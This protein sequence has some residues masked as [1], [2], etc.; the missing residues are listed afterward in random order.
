[1]RGDG[2]D[3]QWVVFPGGD[4]FLSIFER[5]FIRGGIRGG[6]FEDRLAADGPQAC[7]RSRFSDIRLEIIH[8]HEGGH[9]AAD[10]LGTGQLGAQTD[11]FG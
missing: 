10:R 1:M 6:E 7:F 5:I 3:D 8:I 2:G 4:E 11:K 9:A